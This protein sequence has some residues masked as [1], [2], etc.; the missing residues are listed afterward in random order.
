[1]SVNTIHALNNDAMAVFT[2]LLNHESSQIRAKAAR[3]VMD[4]RYVCMYLHFLEF[5]IK[6]TFIKYYVN[7]L[8]P[9]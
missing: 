2:D 4:L 1:M 9:A 8:G 5:E 6:Y 3:D 7:T